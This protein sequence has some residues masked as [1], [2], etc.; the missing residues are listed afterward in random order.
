M[1][2]AKPRIDVGLN[3]HRLEPLLDFWQNT[4][5]LP[6]DHVLPIR[7]GVKQHRHELLGSILKINHYREPM[8][9]IP[10]SGYREL[11]IAR[12]G[13]TGPRALRDPDGNRVTLVPSGTDRIERIGIRLEVRDIAAHRRFFKEAMQLEEIAADSAEAAFRAGDSVILLNR[14]ASALDDARLEGAGWRYLTF[15]VF[16]VDREHAGAISRGAIEGLAPVTLGSVARI[17]MIRDPDGNWIE[18]SQR[19]SITGSLTAE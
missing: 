1:Q 16:Q 2:L 8:R 19:A 12:D 9:D 11:L 15:Q 7:R 5:G 6:L 18:L 13:V 14:S 4:V 10:P 3:T 17:S